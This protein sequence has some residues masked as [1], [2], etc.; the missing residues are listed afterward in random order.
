MTSIPQTWKPRFREAELL[1]HGLQWI[2]VLLGV[3]S[4]LTMPWPTFLLPRPQH[5]RQ[6]PSGFRPLYLETFSTHSAASSPLSVEKMMLLESHRLSPSLNHTL[7]SVQSFSHSERSWEKRHLHALIPATRRHRAP[8]ARH[9]HL[10]VTWHSCSQGRLSA[11]KCQITMRQ[12]DNMP[13]E[14]SSLPAHERGSKISPGIFSTSSGFLHWFLGFFG[15]K[16][17]IG[18]EKRREEEKLEHT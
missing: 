5:A 14:S 18:T 16:K 6:F 8:C 10:P 11:W 9:S 13:C 3:S 12:Q 7:F 17:K 15:K 1:V 4:D 2:S